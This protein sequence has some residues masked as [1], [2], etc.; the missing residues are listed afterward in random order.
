MIHEFTNPIP[1]NTVHGEGYAWYVRDGGNFENDVFC[2]ILCDGGIV[3]HYRSDQFTIDKNLTF[4]IKPKTDERQKSKKVTKDSK[5]VRNTNRT[6][7]KQN[8]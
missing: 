7:T 4:D 6:T 2:I 3:R 1:V 5:P 8:R